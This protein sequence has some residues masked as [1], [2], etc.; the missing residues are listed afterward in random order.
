MKDG[1]DMGISSRSVGWSC[2][3]R[4]KGLKQ[5][6]RPLLMEFCPMPAKDKK[7]KDTKTA[8]YPRIRLNKFHKT[9][10]LAMTRIFKAHGFNI[11]REQ[12]A[13]LR[14][15]CS[16]EG[17]NQAELAVLAGQERNNL[18][19]TLNILEEKGLVSRIVCPTDRRNSVVH[20]TSEGRKLHAAVYKAIEEYQHTLFNGL[21]MEQIQTF[22]DTVHFLT[23]NLEDYLMRTND[24][25]E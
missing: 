16:T 12:E 15:L 17:I 10:N 6:H 20:I 9:I 13:I 5:A 3:V 14:A 22:A 2:F 25:A 18:S 1:K 4:R 23:Q 11:T 19:R 21:T 7:S 8:Q 24:D